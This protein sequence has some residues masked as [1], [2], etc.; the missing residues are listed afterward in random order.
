M[1]FVLDPTSPR[2]WFRVFCVRCIYLE[3]TELYACSTEFSWSREWIST[4]KAPLNIFL[5]IRK[6]Q[7]LSSSGIVVGMS[8]DQ[9]SRDLNWELF[10]ECL[11]ENCP[12]LTPLSSH[13]NPSISIDGSEPFL[14]CLEQPSL[15]GS[16]S[17]P[18]PPVK[19]SDALLNACR[20]CTKPTNGHKYYGGQ[21]CHSCRAFFKRSVL[22]GGFTKVPSCNA[23]TPCPIDSRSWMSC[24]PCR[25]QACLNAGM[26]PELVSQRVARSTA[27]RSR[28]LSSQIEGRRRLLAL[29]ASNPGNIRRSS[30]EDKAFLDG[31]VRY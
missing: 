12:S 4:N 29:A 10:Q 7:E 1:K 9:E 5:Q 30:N 13:V 26:I 6:N 19:K 20:V 8:T 28:V 16:L 22:S 11:K 17:V 3:W 25:F 31:Q 2:S 24:K 21:S 23:A 14:D 15:L 18:K 27:T